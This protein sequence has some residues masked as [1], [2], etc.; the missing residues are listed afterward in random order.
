MTGGSLTTMIRGARR[1]SCPKEV[2]LEP[3]ISIQ[4]TSAYKS[5]MSSPS[6]SLMFVMDPDL[7]VSSYLVMTS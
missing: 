1:L 7:S 5:M 4:R 6:S 2:D 3:F